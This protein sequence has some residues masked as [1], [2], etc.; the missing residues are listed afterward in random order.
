[1]ILRRAGPRP[2]VAADLSAVNRREPHR[3]QRREVRAN[4][5]FAYHETTEGSSHSEASLLGTAEALTTRPLTRLMLC[6][7]YT[8]CRP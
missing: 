7:L 6:M 2:A 1:M 5:Q 4:S 8:G 3:A